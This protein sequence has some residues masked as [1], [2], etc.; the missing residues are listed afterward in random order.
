MNDTGNTLT[1]GLMT[2]W[3]LFMAFLPKLL[4]FA[5]ILVVGYFVSRL[6]ERVLDA[7]LER[8]GFDRLVE[9]GG[10][11]QALE[12]SNLDASSFVSKLAKYA[13]ILFT[14]QLAFGVF[15]PNPISDLLTRLIA[16]LPNIFY[17]TL[18]VIIGSA[19]A[20]GVKRILQTTMSNLSFGRMVANGASAAILVVAIFAALAELNIAPTIINGLFYAALFVIAGSLVI[21]MGVGGIAPMRGVWERALG[22]VQAE[23]PKVAQAV[24]SSNPPAAMGS[25]SGPIVAQPVQPKPASGPIITPPPAAPAHEEEPRH[26]D[27]PRFKP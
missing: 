18:I 22:K 11:K 24:A 21:S 6:V 27:V 2:A 19:I 23:A 25:G 17:A 8:V 20:A 7:I 12:K 14:L 10:I 1:A 3:T 26:Q 5:A 15:G 16:Y 13:L 9:R 4:L